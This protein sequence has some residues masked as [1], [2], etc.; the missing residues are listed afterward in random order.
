MPKSGISM[1][2]LAAHGH[3]RGLALGLLIV[4]TTV[5]C[6]GPSVELLT[7]RGGLGPE[8]SGIVSCYTNF[9]VGELVAD[10][11]YGTAI[12]EDNHQTPVMWPP[13]YTARLSGG[14]V[15]VVNKQGD[16]VARTGNHYQ[17]EGGYG[18]QDPTSFVACGYVLSK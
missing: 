8:P 6:G 15:E 9:A 2:S 17:I 4:I 11:A 10:Q 18:G 13:G 16:V 5:G 7:G 1:L 12:V 14:R 3:G